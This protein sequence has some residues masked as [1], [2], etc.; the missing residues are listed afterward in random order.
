MKR[1]LLAASFGLFS[2]AALANSGK[3]SVTVPNTARQNF[4]QQFGAIQQVSWSKA[5]SQMLRADFSIDGQ[6]VTA[7]FNQE[8][9]FLAT[10]VA[11]EKT[12]LPL[13]LRLALEQELKGQT[14]EELYYVEAPTETAYYFASAKNGTRQVYRAYA[15]GH[16]SKVPSL[17]F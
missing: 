10:T 14:I 11:V 16:I 5:K 1:L 6:P 7:F 2:L 15:D 8:G 3:K 4:Q 12:Q 9:E 13:R 17:I